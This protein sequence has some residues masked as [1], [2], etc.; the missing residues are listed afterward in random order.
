[1]PVSVKRSI[2]SVTTEALP[3][4]MRCEHVAV[5]DEGEALLPGAVARA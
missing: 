5:G 2:S 1:M 4:A 3:S